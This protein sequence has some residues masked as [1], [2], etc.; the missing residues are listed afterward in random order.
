VQLE[1]KI[2]HEISPTVQNWLSS[3][4]DKL[5]ME[6]LSKSIYV[7][8]G[9]ITSVIIGESIRDIDVYIN[10]IKTASKL[11][12]YYTNR[13]QSLP[14][15]ENILLYQ[16][17][18]HEGIRIKT[19]GQ[20][21]TN[22]EPPSVPLGSEHPIY[23]SET[24]MSFRSGIQVILGF[25]GSPESVLKRFDFEHARNWCDLTSVY[26]SA[27]A[28]LSIAQR[29]LTFT[30]ATQY[31]LASL[32]RLR[33]FVKRGWKISPGEI[34]KIILCTNRLNLFD[35]HVLREQLVGIDLAYFENIFSALFSHPHDENLSLKTISDAIDSKY[36]TEGTHADNY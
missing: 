22:Y 24:A 16:E 4:K 6:E 28:I 2:L 8:G 25:V 13:L 26:L 10:N 31:P 17:E 18:T 9:A 20:S 15:A 36:N 29:R 19:T 5:L 1:K 21:Y 30:T 11:I 33:K 27:D 32:F 14:S 35:P 3:I 7:A 23:I 12:A 34:L